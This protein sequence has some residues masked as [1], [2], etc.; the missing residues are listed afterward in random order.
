MLSQLLHRSGIDSVVV[1]IRT[2]DDID[3]E[4]TRNTL[5]PNE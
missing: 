4:R 1:D 2:Y 3:T 5:S